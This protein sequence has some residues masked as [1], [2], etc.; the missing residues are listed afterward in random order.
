[1]S[2]VGLSDQCIYLLDGLRSAVDIRAF[3]EVG[4][5]DFRIRKLARDYRDELSHASTGDIGVGSVVAPGFR[6]GNTEFVPHVTKS[7]CGSSYTNLVQ[8]PLTHLSSNR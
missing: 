2:Y 1:M 4:E 3:D 7:A 5:D 8:Q 6:L